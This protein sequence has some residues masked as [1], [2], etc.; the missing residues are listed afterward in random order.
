[1]DSC[2]LYPESDETLMEVL[3]AI[4]SLGEEPALVQAGGN[5]STRVYPCRMKTSQSLYEVS[6]HHTEEVA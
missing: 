2:D 3:R 1:M 6:R 4:G 5:L